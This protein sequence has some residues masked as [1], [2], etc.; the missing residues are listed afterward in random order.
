MGEVIKEE[1]FGGM[2]FWFEV[3]GFGI[4]EGRLVGWGRLK[5]S[6]EWFCVW[7]RFEVGGGLWGI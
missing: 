3:F 2:R 6:G 5:V 7:L 4:L 1:C